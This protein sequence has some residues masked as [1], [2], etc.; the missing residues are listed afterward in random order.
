MYRHT[1]FIAVLLIL[2]NTGSK[3]KIYPIGMTNRMSVY[4]LLKY[5]TLNP[6][7]H[8]YWPV[9]LVVVAFC[10]KSL[11]Q[12]A[13]KRNWL[14]LGFTNP[15]CEKLEPLNSEKWEFTSGCK[16]GTVFMV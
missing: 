3:L 9:I 7:L 8:F 12:N 4:V 5:S 14:G 16:F 11:M 6:F 15:S 2:D 10:D 1:V 13:S